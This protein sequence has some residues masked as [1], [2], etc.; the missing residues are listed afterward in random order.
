M[1]ATDIVNNIKCG[2]VEYRVEYRKNTLMG[3][4]NLMGRAIDIG[5]NICM[6]HKIQAIA[7]NIITFVVYN[8]ERKLYHIRNYFYR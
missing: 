7:T 8:H 4:S 3:V 2:N 6:E 1:E 5:V